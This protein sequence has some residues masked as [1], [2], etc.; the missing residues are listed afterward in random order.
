[1]CKES[2]GANVSTNRKAYDKY[3][4]VDAP[5]E[6]KEKIENNYENITIIEKD[7]NSKTVAVVDG[8]VIEVWYY[9]EKQYDITTEVK[10]H[11]ETIN[12]VETQV[13]GGTISK[14]Y[15]LDEQGKEVEVNY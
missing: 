2:V 4:S 8:K 11:N 6:T 14:A 9:Y 13:A 3:I 5:E 15:K 1:M 12:G 10:T 7:D